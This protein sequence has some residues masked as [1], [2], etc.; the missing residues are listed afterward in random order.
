MFHKIQEQESCLSKLAVWF[1]F[2]YGQ[3]IKHIFL[4]CIDICDNMLVDSRIPCDME[5]SF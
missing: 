2:G 5:N 1:I 3:Q 4:K